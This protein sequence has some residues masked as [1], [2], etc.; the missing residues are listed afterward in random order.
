MTLRR[1]DEGKLCVWVGVEGMPLRRRR[2]SHTYLHC[3]FD[4]LIFAKTGIIITTQ[5]FEKSI[6]EKRVKKKGC[7]LE[8]LRLGVQREREQNCHWHQG[9][10]VEKT[11]LDA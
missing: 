6:G 4:S 8:G 10:K 2:S 7:P 1:G 11:L 9:K 5:Y 3:L